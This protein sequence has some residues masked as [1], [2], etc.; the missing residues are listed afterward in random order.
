MIE[1]EIQK[2]DRL[3]DKK[4]Q[5]VQSLLQTK[6]SLDCSLINSDLVYLYNEMLTLSYS[7][8]LWLLNGLSSINKGAEEI[9]EGVQGQFENILNLIDRDELLKCKKTITMRC[10]LPYQPLSQ[11]I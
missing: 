9:L 6:K 8:K 3:L 1:K 5:R 4:I 2:I 7:L 10:I 11:A